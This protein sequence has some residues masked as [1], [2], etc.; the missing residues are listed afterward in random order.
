M[1]QATDVQEPI[2]ISQI[3]G[4]YLLFDINVVTYLRRA[5]HICGV[6]IGSLPQVPSQNV[7][8]GLP[9]ELMPEE[10]KLLVEKGIAYIVDDTAWHSRKFNGTD[11]AERHRYAEQLRE[12]GMRAKK[13]A[14]ATNKKKRD[15]KLAQI[16]RLQEEANVKSSSTGEDAGVDENASE[17]SFFSGTTSTL[18]LKK[19]KLAA[20]PYAITPTAT[21]SLLSPPPESAFQQL[22]LVPKSYPLYKHLHSQ[23]YFSTP[24]LRFGCDY[25]VYPGDPLRF[26]SHFV[27][28]GYEWDQEIS[29]MEIIGGGRLGT[30]TKKGFLIG[31]EDLSKMASGE[32]E[33]KDNVRTFCIEWGGM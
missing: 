14:E 13:A 15:K 10:A 32:D 28:V 1:P 9:L 19:A 4:H 31:G 3:A 24:G 11:A 25:T 30:G 12:Q 18:P 8:L 20:E 26:H 27:A 33:D 2:A 17:A 5:H 16:G 29:L 21:E 6:L 22:P 23:N 7:F